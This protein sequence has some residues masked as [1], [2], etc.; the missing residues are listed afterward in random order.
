MTD[1]VRER[2]VTTNQQQMPIN[3]PG[4]IKVPSVPL[5]AQSATLNQQLSQQT[6]SNYN[7][8]ETLPRDTL[9]SSKID[10]SRQ[11][12]LEDM[13]ETMGESNIRTTTGTRE[14]TYGTG[15]TT[16]FSTGLR[17]TQTA[18][19]SQITVIDKKLIV[20][21]IN[22]VHFETQYVQKTIPVAKELTNEMTIV[23][24]VQETRR[25]PVTKLVEIVEQVPIKVVEEVMEYK[26]IPVTKF[27]EVIE[28]V[29]VKKY[30]PRTE[31]KKV[32]VTKLVERTEN[33]SVRRVKEEIEYVDI[34]TVNPI[35]PTPL[36]NYHEKHSGII[37]SSYMAQSSGTTGSNFNA[38]STGANFNATSTGANFNATSSGANFNAI[39]SS[40]IK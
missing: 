24:A 33:V 20:E 7:A 19:Y 15:M 34:V 26:T 37:Q 28:Q 17:E 27:E 8:K 39:K 2:D 36:D 29:P 6:S 25:V 13:R 16:G 23:T 38:T 4:D 14:S 9:R 12:R 21:K 40:N 35:N 5:Q 18:N 22:E 32:Q 3:K 11:S 30:V 31:Y 10:E 1:L